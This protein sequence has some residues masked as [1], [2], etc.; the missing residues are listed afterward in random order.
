MMYSLLDKIY[1][2]CARR[3]A[4]RIAY[5]YQCVMFVTYLKKF[6]KKHIKLR[7]RDSREHVELL[8]YI[9]RHSETCDAIIQYIT[10]HQKEIISIL[11]NHYCKKSNGRLTYYHLRYAP[12]RECIRT[13]ALEAICT[14]SAKEN[15]EIYNMLN[16]IVCMAEDLRNGF[17]T[18]DNA[19]KTKIREHWIQ[20]PPHIALFT[21]IVIMLRLFYVM[22]TKQFYVFDVDDTMYLIFTIMGFVSIYMVYLRVPQ[23]IC[24]EAKKSAQEVYMNHKIN[25]H[26]ELLDTCGDV[27][28]Y[29]NNQLQHY[30][31][32]N[33][34]DFKIVVE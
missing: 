15:V 3:H 17:V 22:Y 13:R 29:M 19:A 2:K 21:L 27:N 24:A 16:N 6:L 26:F 7:T 30:L 4:Q 1:G 14:T 8:A 10:Y 12:M 20:R 5:Q 23:C 11:C 31:P 18:S 32:N 25:L 33:K 34:N 9:E 28:E